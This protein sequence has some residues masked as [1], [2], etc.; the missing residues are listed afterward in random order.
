MRFRS[1]RKVFVLACLLC[2]L[3]VVPVYAVS[4]DAPADASTVQVVTAPKYAPYIGSGWISGTAAGLGEVYVYVP[5]SS[6]GFWG[7]TDDGYLCNVG[8][9]SVSGVMFTASGTKYAFSCSSFSV[10]RYRLYDSSGYQYSDLHLT[11][12]GSNLDVATTFPGSYT[13]ANSWPYIV[14]G[15]M[16]VI[17]VCMMRYKR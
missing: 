8:G 15:L 9:S 6:H 12:T 14:I 3:C 2:C 11:V 7:T 13:F 16:G 10:P 4:N 5:I 1:V 17:L